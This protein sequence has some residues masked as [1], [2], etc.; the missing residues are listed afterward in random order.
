MEDG[1]VLNENKYLSTVII[2]QGM[3]NGQQPRVYKIAF[4]EGHCQT[5]NSASKNTL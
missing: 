4:E 1:I 5:N 2:D 3:Q